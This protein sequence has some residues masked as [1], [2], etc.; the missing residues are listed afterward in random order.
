MTPAEEVFDRIA[1][2]TR[3]L[4]WLDDVFKARRA[5]G[6]EIPLVFTE[7]REAWAEIYRDK[8]AVTDGL[9][10]DDWVQLRKL[11]KVPA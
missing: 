4:S 5:R 9:T 10:A 11:V 8:A 6:E 7:W 3:L 2:P 1:P